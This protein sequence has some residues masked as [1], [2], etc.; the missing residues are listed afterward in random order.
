[1]YAAYSR[2]EVTYAWKYMKIVLIIGGY[3]QFG[4]RLSQRLKNVPDIRV[5][6]AGRNY[7]KA[8]ALCKKY[9]GNLFPA[10][11]DTQDD[12]TSQIK[13]LSPW[14]IVNA[15]G[16]FQPTFSQ[17]YPL[18]QACIKQGI[19]YIDLSDSA[20]FTMGIST[21]DSAAKKAGIAAISGASSV[22]A[23]SSA[24]VVE[25]SKN[26]TSIDS[27]EGGISPGG[28]ID[29]GLS[30]TQAVL[31]YLGKPLKVF[32]GGEWGSETG[33]SRI[34]SHTI[35]IEGQEPLRR[36]FGLCDA[37][38]LR[39]FPAHF[40]GVKTVRFYG[41]Q[42]SWV[43]H[44]SIKLLAWLQK[45]R[46]IKHLESHARFFQWWGTQLGKFASERGG[47]FM[48]IKGIHNEGSLASQQWNLIANQGD[49]PFI[50]ILAAEILIKRWLAHP[51][52]SG[53][54]SATSEITLKEFRMIFDSL[55]IQSSFSNMRPAPPLFQHVLGEKYRTLP[56]ALQ[57][58]HNVMSYKTMRGNVDIIRGKN[59]LAHLLANIIGFAKSQTS[60][61]I[62][63]TMDVK[64]DREV[65]TRTI[66]ASTFTST[67]SPGN[68]PC[69]IYE[70]FGLVKFKMIFRI[71]DSKLHYDI[72]SAK[73]FGVPLP[74]FLRPKSVTHEREED[75]KFIF[76]VEIILPLFGRLISYKGWLV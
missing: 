66:G 27:I 62:S 28:N 31:S 10:V 7:N 44:Q 69:E 47:M 23:L 13:E 45:R 76:D 20:E 73:I 6:V 68:R 4:S 15:S 46:L 55:A 42:E 14:L 67:L 71:E 18:V 11:F 56:T 33:Y 9:G 51:P 19:Y 12:L 2:N 54:R 8:Q 17:N 37:P 60:A 48:L 30:V 43:I 25:A 75:D 39:I 70:Q 40:K 1:M 52:Q 72:I 49:G 64:G 21:L 74:A 24:V 26:F 3:G 59:P 61:P 5:L 29:I 36:W 35:T 65:W 50:P 41:S 63:I 34:H 32:R 38:D 58:G 53:A 22:P 57:D 16:P